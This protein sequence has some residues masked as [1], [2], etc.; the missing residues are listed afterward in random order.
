MNQLN[1]KNKL[2]GVMPND[3]PIQVCALIEQAFSSQL[4]GRAYKKNKERFEVSKRNIA[5]H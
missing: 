2:Q 3:N 1:R 5:H 4:N